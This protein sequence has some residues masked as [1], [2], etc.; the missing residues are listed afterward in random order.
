[1]ALLLVLLMLFSATPALAQAGELPAPFCGKLAKKDCDLIKKA[2]AA[3]LELSSYTV[4]SEMNFSVSGVPELPIE[5]I[6]VGLA[7]DAILRMDPE[8]MAE[9]AALNGMDPAD[10]MGNM[11]ELADLVVRFY[12]NIGLDLVVT[13]TISKEI[14]DLISADAPFEMPEE[15]SLHVVLLDGFAYV[16]TEDLEFIDPMVTSMGKWV[17]IDFAGLMQM[18]MNEALAQQQS[19]EAQG[20]MSGMALGS[21]F[22]S[23]QIRGLVEDYVVIERLKDAKVDNQAVAVFETTFDFAGFVASDGLWDFV[24]EN[25]EII[26]AMSETKVS[27]SELQEARMAL[28]F[29]GPA[30]FQT[31]D[32]V[33][34]QSIGIKD[35]YPYASELALNWD[36]STIMAF[37]AAMDSGAARGQGDGPQAVINLDVSTVSGDFNDAPEI[38][39]PADAAIVPLEALQNME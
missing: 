33:T 11:E 39:A 38:E 4:N 37:A 2:Q 12:E 5:E 13:L 18:A 25:L 21:M 6:T 30:L 35:Y 26:N 34:T 8:L 7:Q 3:A 24:D 22:S 20:M 1:M 36:L 15:V 31:L 29:L 32:F 27:K 9:M 10:L 23:E 14:A 19:P 17:G 28:T 16:D